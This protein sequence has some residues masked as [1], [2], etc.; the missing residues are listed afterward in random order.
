MIF[1]RRQYAGL[2]LLALLLTS[3][4]RKI[5]CDYFLLNHFTGEVAIIYGCADGDNIN[6]KNGRQQYYIPN[7][8]ILLTKEKFQ[9][10]EL[11]QKFYTLSKNNIY[12]VPVFQYQKDTTKNYIYF[13]RF[14]TI[15]CALRDNTAKEYSVKFFYVGKKMDSS[16]N[17][18]RFQFEKQIRSL[19]GCSE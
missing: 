2:L 3:C 13:D 15:A 10:G 18:N 11:D 4:N 6:I 17:K 9:A 12:E 1:V 8:G 5:K 19:L 16:S 7:S 14:E